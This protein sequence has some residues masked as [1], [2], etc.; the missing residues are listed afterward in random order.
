MGRVLVIGK[1]I[2]ELKTLLSCQKQQF[3]RLPV[4]GTERAEQMQAAI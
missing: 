4:V 2:V 3:T 1:K